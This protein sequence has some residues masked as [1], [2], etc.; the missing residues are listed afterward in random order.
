MNSPRV[1]PAN[2]PTHGNLST[3]SRR[4]PGPIIPVVCR[5]RR[6]LTAVL[7]RGAAAY[8]SRRSP[9]RRLYSR[10]SNNPRWL[11]QLRD[12]AAG[13]A[14]GLLRFPYPLPSEGA[15]NA[16]R[17]M[18]PIAACATIVVER[19]RVFRS[20]RNHPAFPAQWFSG[21]CRTL[22]GDRA[23][24]SPSPAGISSRRLDASVEAS[25]PYD[26]AVRRP[27]RPSSAHPASTASRSAFRDVAQRPSVG[28]DDASMD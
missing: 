23:F 3:S 5:C 16:G 28:R 6:C 15:G 25:G 2:P 14:R 7:D 11:T 13:F 10:I 27:P 1:S 4:T 24:L 21:L 19:T 12:L 9:G 17:P 20:H 18:R 8:G 26:F 22:P